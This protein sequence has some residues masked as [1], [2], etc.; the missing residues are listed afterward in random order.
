MPPS[1]FILSNGVVVAALTSLVLS[2]NYFFSNFA[3]FSEAEYQV[4]ER[5]ELADAKEQYDRWR[6]Q[7]VHS[8]KQIQDEAQL[9]VRA[10]PLIE[11]TLLSVVV[12]ID[13][14]GQP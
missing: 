2:I 5:K 7:H 9:K 13:R 14:S 11:C 6:E 8:L 10:G 4:T 1:A 12:T 3:F